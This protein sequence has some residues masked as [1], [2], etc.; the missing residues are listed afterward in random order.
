MA[1]RRHGTLLEFSSGLAQLQVSAVLSVLAIRRL[2]H[3]EC[4]FSPVTPGQLGYECK[5]CVSVNVHVGDR[6]L[7]KEDAILE[8]VVRPGGQLVLGIKL[9]LWDIRSWRRFYIRPWGDNL[10]P[11]RALH[12]GLWVRLRRLRG[13]IIL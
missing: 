4:A 2:P 7:K 11:T 1:G 10:W 5:W 3:F 8:Q 9:S 6:S 13:C 12:Y